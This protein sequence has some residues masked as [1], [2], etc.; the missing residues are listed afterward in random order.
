MI[1]KFAAMALAIALV[2]TSAIPAAEAGPR[3]RGYDNHGG[4][5][6]HG[7]HHRGRG[8]YKNGKWIAL[9]ILGAVAAAAVANSE[10]SGCYY[11]RGRRYCD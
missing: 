8:H 11:R 5:R 9:G 4:E 1:K 7:R 10:S 2:T 6:D 3:G